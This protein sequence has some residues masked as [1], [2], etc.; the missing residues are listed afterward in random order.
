MSA[1]TAPDVSVV[2]PFRDEAPTLAPLLEGIAAG[3]A[4]AGV[5]HE[6]ILIDD[7]S[8]DGGRQVARDLLA[9]HPE[10][11]LIAFRRNFGKAA[12]LSA[13]FKRAGAPVVVT[14][15]ADLQDD[16]AEIPRFLAC[17]ADG[18]DVVSGWKKKRHDPLSKTLP[19]RL[20]NGVVGR[21]F[22]L[23]LHDFNCGFKAYRRAA[24]GGL[25]LYGEL[26]RFIPALLAGSG[27]SVAEIEVNHRPRRAG[28]SKYGPSRMLKGLLDLFTVLLITRY[29]T[30]PLHLIGLPGLALSGVGLVICAYLSVLWFLGLGPIGDRPLL[31]LGVLCLISGIQLIGVGL[32]GE[33]LVTLLMRE[34][35]KYVIESVEGGP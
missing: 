34:D 30:R 25:D 8:R 9:A 27:Y 13:G 15:D 16:P 22:G 31:M 4:A 21:V 32:I 28:R 1:P 11:R 3:C 26:H 18:H 10:A 20:F 12:A 33:M 35:H 17:L 7:G 24:L 19:S 14:M 2:V 5:R 29:R 23:P 6:V